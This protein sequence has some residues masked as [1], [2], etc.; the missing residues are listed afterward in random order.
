MSK[1]VTY[2]TADALKAYSAQ[3]LLGAR[4]IN[5][6]IAGARYSYTMGQ[7]GTAR[8]NVMRINKELRARGV[9]PA[10]GKA[11]AKADTTGLVKAAIEPLKAAAVE[12]AVEEATAYVA[13][14][15]AA[16]EG[17]NINEAF[18]YPKGEPTYSEAYKRVRAQRSALMSL[19]VAERLP[20]DQYK[21]HAPMFLRSSDT[22]AAR[23]IKGARRD[24]EASFDAYVA[25]LVLKVG[26]GVTKATV[27]GTRLWMA[28]IL[29]VTKGASVERWKTQQIVNYS[30]LGNAYLQ[31]PTRKMK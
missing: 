31:W 4:S 14:V 26:E 18:P 16:Y 22:L 2:L 8:G 28:S 23:F 6:D 20:E 10:T 29:T 15:T 3:Q 12:H 30:V 13:R 19:M 17:K 1:T 5:R 21:P 9:D 7:L 11:A 24:A 27:D 25:K